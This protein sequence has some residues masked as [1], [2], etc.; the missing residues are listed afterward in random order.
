MGTE[1]W[2][3][4]LENG[5]LTA[6]ASYHRGLSTI[7]TMRMV[8]LREEVPLDEGAPSSEDV[9]AYDL[10]SAIFIAGIDAYCPELIET[11]YGSLF[12]IGFDEAWEDLTGGPAPYRPIRLPGN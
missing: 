1:P 9:D 7:D 8:M 5:A 10:L 12:G 4:M 2:F 11:I 6:C 3:R